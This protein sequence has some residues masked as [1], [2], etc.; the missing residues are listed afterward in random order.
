MN[1]TYQV[2]PGNDGRPALRRSRT[3]AERS[4]GWFGRR[5]AARQDSGTEES[6]RG[7]VDASAM[8]GLADEGGGTG[9][10]RVGAWLQH[11]E[12]GPAE[13]AGRRR[14]S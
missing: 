4:R 3:T 6:S 1:E 11:V 5:Q 2:T 8:A 13:T 7:S 12:S 9:A 10:G 14:A